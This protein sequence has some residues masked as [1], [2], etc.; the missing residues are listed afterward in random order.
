MSLLSKDLPHNNSNRRPLNDVTEEG[1]NTLFRHVV[2]QPTELCNLNCQYCYLPGRRNATQ[3]SVEVVHAV[4]RSI[5]SLDYKVDVVWHG[6]EPLAAGIH[7]MRALLRPFEDLRR[8]GKVHH[9]IQTNA[10]LISRE[11]CDLFIQEDFGVGVS[12]DG[13]ES[14]NR[15]RVTWANAPSH[16]QV[17]KGIELLHEYHIPFG[18]I[19]VVNRQNLNDACG[20]YAFFVS[21]GCDLLNINVVEREGLNRMSEDLDDTSVKRFWSDLFK[22]WKSNPVL[23]IREFD[24]ALGWMTHALEDELQTE[25]FARDF[26]PT[27][28]CTG[29]VVVLSP[30]FLSVE[31]GISQQFVVGNVLRTPLNE[32]VRQSVDAWYVRDFLRG[33]ESCSRCCPYFEYCGGGQASNKYFELGDIGGMETAQCRNTRQFLIDAVL[34]SVLAQQKEAL[35]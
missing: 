28:S 26:W 20:L 19:A 18:V 3:M 4:A 6:G 33:M 27:V 31:P 22:A 29:D 5:A 25:R 14:H 2:L 32:I 21:L 1:T 23:K 13:N 24:S 11:W 35:L 15:G 8:S 34:D 12:L 9:S 17:M 16:H 7:T 10:T 30:E